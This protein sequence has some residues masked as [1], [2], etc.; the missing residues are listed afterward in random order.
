MTRIHLGSASTGPGRKAWGQ[1]RVA[2]GKKDVRLP[3][4]VIHGAQPGPHV[5]MIPGAPTSD[6]LISTGD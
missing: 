2:Q 1:L 3:V 4:A 5:V 6:I